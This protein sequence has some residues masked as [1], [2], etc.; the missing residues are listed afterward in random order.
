M[1]QKKGL[2]VVSSREVSDCR[3]VYLQFCLVLYS[4]AFEVIF[5]IL[6]ILNAITIAVQVQYL[7]FDTAHKLGWP[8]ATTGSK[9]TWPT[10]GPAFILAEYFFGIVF[11]LEVA[12]KLAA[13]PK[14]CVKSAWNVFDALI[15]GFWLVSL[16]ASSGGFMNPTLLRLARLVR[17]LR[18]LRLVR[19]VQMFDVLRILIGS[20][21]ASFSVLMWSLVVLVLIVLSTALVLN[22]ALEDYIADKSNPI[23]ARKEVFEL[24]GSCS[25]SAVTAFEMTLGNWVVPLRELQENVSEWYG[26]VILVYVC[27][28]S[29]AII[30][31]T[32]AVFME[33]TFRV[34]ASDED[35][36]IMKEER[37]IEKHIRDMSRFFTE[38]DESGNG[39]LSLDE[40]K[41][42]TADPRVKAWLSTIGIDMSNGSA[43]HVFELIEGEEDGHISAEE[44]V[45]GMAKL[46]GPARSLGLLQLARQFDAIERMYVRLEKQISRTQTM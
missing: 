45:Q 28:V 23:E 29:F 19:T 38:G 14:R 16:L 11:T 33:Q 6:I 5:A 20:L 13:G 43:E 8:G 46:K 2:P 17:L 18:L 37:A 21:R 9:D 40:F 30:Q 7:S 1:P 4:D 22:F 35:L 26:L 27:V 3:R 32:R 31:V 12:A 36:V 25:R 39:F 24:F 10:A 41:S 42:I 15:I 34:A 44:L